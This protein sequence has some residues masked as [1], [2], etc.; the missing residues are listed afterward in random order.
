M[1]RRLPLT[2]DFSASPLEKQALRIEGRHVDVSSHPDYPLY[3]PPGG[4]FCLADWNRAR[5]FDTGGV[6]R[7]LTA[8]DVRHARR[9]DGHEL[10]VGI[11]R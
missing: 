7:D 2:R 9:H 8:P 1:C 5:R 10:H 11:E 4:F 3:P 6:C